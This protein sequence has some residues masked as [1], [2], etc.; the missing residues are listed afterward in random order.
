[1]DIKCFRLLS[2]L[3]KNYSIPGK[4]GINFT[5]LFNFLPQNAMDSFAQVKF[6]LVKILL[7]GLKL[8]FI[9][10]LILISFFLFTNAF[11]QYLR[12]TNLT[13]VFLLEVFQSDFPILWHA[14]ISLFWT[15]TSTSY[16]MEVT[17]SSK[18]S[19]ATSSEYQI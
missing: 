15:I 2:F 13:M 1:M 10:L 17:T 19:S 3:N 5:I 14:S 12:L 7:F 11:L 6:L 4:T 8:Y 9:S 16:I 18:S